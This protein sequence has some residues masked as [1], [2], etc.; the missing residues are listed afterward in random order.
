MAHENPN[1]DPLVK[2]ISDL[3]GIVTDAQTAHT[4]N[5]KALRDELTAEKVASTERKAKVEELTTKLADDSAKLGNLQGVIDT[6]KRQLD[7]PLLTGTQK[8]SRD[9]VKETV[10]LHMRDVH[11]ATHLGNSEFKEADLDL[12]FIPSLVS[13]QRKL[14]KSKN[15]S[16]QDRKSVV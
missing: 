13:A 15:E 5:I 6:M 4:E 11:E 10:I 2:A 8:E 12:G 3:K 1:G 7:Q 14:V 16:D 9:A